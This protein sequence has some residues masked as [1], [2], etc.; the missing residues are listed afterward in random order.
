MKHDE[1]CEAV[2]WTDRDDGHDCR[3]GSRA[4][5]REKEEGNEQR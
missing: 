4:Y 5:E 2:D 3:C 1:Y